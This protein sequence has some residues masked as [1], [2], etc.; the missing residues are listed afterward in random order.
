MARVHI[1]SATFEELLSIPGV[2]AKIAAK[3]WELREDKGILELEDLREVPYMRITEAA[4][5]SM[6]FST[7]LPPNRGSNKFCKEEIGHQEKHLNFQD[8]GELNRGFREDMG[9]HQ[10]QWDRPM[11]AYGGPRD[12]RYE[13]ETPRSRYNNAGD[14]GR[15]RGGF[16]NQYIDNEGPRLR[17]AQPE[18]EAP[19]SRHASSMGYPTGSGEP[20]RGYGDQRSSRRD[21]YD[22]QGN[23]GGSDNQRQRGS[24]G[25][26]LPS[27]KRA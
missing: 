4:L 27:Y 9:T 5:E 25:L 19:A 6:D 12:Y 7:S 16:Q 20:R 18:S 10:D 3:I 22:H 24:M 11:G 17:D 14:T 26:D 23:M 15:G 8:G 1:N 21:A 13:G 2:G